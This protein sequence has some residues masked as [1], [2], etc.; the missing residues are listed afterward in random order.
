MIKIQISEQIVRSKPK[1]ISKR[2]RQVL[3]NC[4]EL[5][6]NSG[7]GRRNYHNLL[8]L[9][10]TR[11]QRGGSRLLSGISTALLIPNLNTYESIELSRAQMQRSRLDR[12]V[13]Q[14]RIAVSCFIALSTSDAGL[15]ALNDGCQMMM[16]GLVEAV[17]VSM[18]RLELTTEFF[19]VPSPSGPPPPP[20]Y[21]PP[22]P[23]PP[24]I[25][26]RD[27]WVAPLLIFSSLTMILIA[28][29]EEREIVRE[30]EREIVREK[31]REREERGER[32]REREREK[33]RERVR[34]KEREC[35][36][37]LP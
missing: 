10:G 33:D 2:I 21:L 8:R 27:M 28:L 13:D 4:T 36:M 1:V 20:P 22:A 6:N 15:S 30:K 34:E 25:L 12:R 17:N 29:F 11:N 14:L 35:R 18:G 32:E 7:D 24:G 5:Q 9:L 31:E 16:E 19:L 26:R 37:T 3:P 23:P